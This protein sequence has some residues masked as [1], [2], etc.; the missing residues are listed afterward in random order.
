MLQGLF[1][2]LEDPCP[3]DYVNFHYGFNYT[4]VYIYALSMILAC[5]IMELST[6]STPYQLRE[7]LVTNAVMLPFM[8]VH[9]QRFQHILSLSY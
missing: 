5:I 3:I 8:F 2:N 9:S 6:R 4:F 7:F 1:V